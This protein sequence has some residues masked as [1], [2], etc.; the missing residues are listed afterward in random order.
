MALPLGK[1]TILVGAGIVGSVLAK[2]GRLPNVLD[3]F[4]GAFKIAWRQIRQDNSTR[5]IPKSGNA[6]LMQQVLADVL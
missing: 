6:S 3:I 2:E 5:S 4:S 1:L